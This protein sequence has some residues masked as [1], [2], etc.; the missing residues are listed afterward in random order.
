VSLSPSYAII[1]STRVYG[2]EDKHPRRR[3]NQRR[4]R[5]RPPRAVPAA[6]AAIG[7]F[8]LLVSEIPQ[9]LLIYL[10]PQRRYS[11]GRRRADSLPWDWLALVGMTCLRPLEAIRARARA[12]MRMAVRQMAVS[13]L[14]GDDQNRERDSRY[15]S[16][17]PAWAALCIGRAV[18][19]PPSRVKMPSSPKKEGR[20][21]TNGITPVLASQSC[22][23]HPTS[24]YR[25]TKAKMEG[26]EEK[27]T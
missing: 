24:E 7:Q 23:V 18:T 14:V 6:T 25:H 2:G 8:L 15:R 19:P 16:S 1:S 4:P 17:T 26:K 3:W 9:R 11:E 21:G 22:L 13:L 12:R 10:Q 27:P 5:H 20:R